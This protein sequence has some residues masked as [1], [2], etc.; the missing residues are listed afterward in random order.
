MN[1]LWLSQSIPSSIE[2]NR[3]L[4]NTYFML[5]LTL[6]CSAL[7]AGIA[8]A[9]DVRFFSPILFLVIAIGFPFALQALRNSVWG[10][11]LTFAYTAFIGWTLGPILNMY[12]HEFSN[13]AQLIMMALGGTGL[14]FLGLSAIALNPNRNFFK[15]APFIFVGCLVALVLMVVGMFIHAPAFQITVSI[16]FA[17]IAGAMILFQ[18]NSII[19]GGE[20]NYLI[21]T[22]NLYVSI[23]NIFLTLLRLLAMFSGNRNN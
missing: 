5:S 19:H 7:F 6:I 22:V 17:I 13:G 9:M 14:I 1:S 15:L 2:V 23:L 4:R 18:T 21:A 10:I 11:A 16:L 8:M 20:R 12:I 3:V